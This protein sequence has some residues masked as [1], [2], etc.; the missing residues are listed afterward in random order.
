METS[1][2]YHNLIE[3]FGEE[4]CAVCRLALRDVHRHL[5]SLLY[6]YV[7]E[8][9]TNTAFRRSRGL[10]N[11]HSWQL[12]QFKS[13]VLGVSILYDAALDEVVKLLDAA[14]V[15]PQ[16]RLSRWLGG[17]HEDSPAH[18][19]DALEPEIPCEACTI[20]EAGEQRT[21]TVLR[22]HSGDAALMDAY[23]A[24]EGLCLPHFR[25]LLRALDGS[26]HAPR[27]VAIQRD[28]WARLKAEVA[29]FIDKNDYQWSGD[30]I[31]QEGTSWQ[32]A[33]ARIAGEKG[34]WGL[35]RSR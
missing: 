19:A 23:R 26:E 2:V 25:M 8:P 33:I 28:I 9:T 18:L 21:I 30:P 1:F 22:E 32:R 4:G 27:Y 7:T 5:D 10:C 11:E 29:L 35:R 17:Q 16:S 34:V 13:T 31:G 20:L 24:S 14:A 3:A 15:T 6:E 12:R